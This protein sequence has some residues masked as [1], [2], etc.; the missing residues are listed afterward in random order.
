MLELIGLGLTVGA[1]LVGYV[2]TKDFTK[3]KLRF[4]DAA[5]APSA[6][7]VAGLGA[8]LITIPFWLL[9]AVGVGTAVVVG[10]A[11]G[12]GMRSGQKERHLLP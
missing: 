9:P 11:V 5:Q 1:G 4:V 2:S 7:V 12:L 3:R 6:P 8:A 10:A